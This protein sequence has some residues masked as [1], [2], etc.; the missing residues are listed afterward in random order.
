M[1]FTVIPLELVG[2][3]LSKPCRFKLIGDETCLWSLFA[4]TEQQG[5]HVDDV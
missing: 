3:Y 1:S 2:G 5:V 4:V